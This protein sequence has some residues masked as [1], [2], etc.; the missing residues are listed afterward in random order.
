M[1]LGCLIND[2]WKLKNMLYFVMIDNLGDHINL[3]IPILGCSLF[4]GRGKKNLG[5]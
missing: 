4:G 2:V 5:F 3:K 1:N